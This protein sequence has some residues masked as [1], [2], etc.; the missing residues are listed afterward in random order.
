[1]SVDDRSF[2]FL[3]KEY[4]GSRLV[5]MTG[6]WSAKRVLRRAPSSRF[7]KSALRVNK[8][9][10]LAFQGHEAWILD[11]LPRFVFELPI[12]FNI[13]LAPTSPGTAAVSSTAFAV[14][15]S[16]ILRAGAR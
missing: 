12:E 8:D 10:P 4:A 14:S 6:I 9:L 7:D 2:A 5:S 13:A 3:A 15:A 1:M 11:S 16:S